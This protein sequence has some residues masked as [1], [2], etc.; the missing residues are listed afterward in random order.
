MKAR[1]ATPKSK[2]GADKPS[3]DHLIDEA[4]KETFPASDPPFFV[5]GCAKPDIAKPDAPARKECHHP[6]RQ[7]K[8]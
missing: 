7:G 1:K 3:P 8:R 5:G 2:S 4:L 6:A